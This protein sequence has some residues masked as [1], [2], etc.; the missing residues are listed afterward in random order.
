MPPPS[1]TAHARDPAAPTPRR[2]KESAKVHPV[3][4]EANGAERKM[5]AGKWR[6]PEWCSAAGA[7]GVL[8]RH[9]APALFGCGL[10]L[11]MAVEYT[12]PMVPPAAPPL[13]LGFLATAGMH[14]AV[15]ARPWLNSLLA[16]LN[17][18]FVAIQA[19]YILWAILAEGRPRAAVAALMMFTCRG[20]LGCATQLPLPEEFLGSGMDFPVGN[21]S[22]FL[23]FSGHV[24]GAVIAAADMRREGRL[25][26][27]RLYD[28]LNVMQGVRLLACRGH[29]TI[30]LAVGVGAGMLF[31]TLAG[32]YFDGK[33]FDSNA[34]ERHCRSCQCHKALLSQ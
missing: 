10:L 21:V 11:F 29:Y 3:V 9:P 17:T 23:F 15:A 18:V 22:F 34:A 5:G 12:I 27:A 4:A 24:A 26:L 7:A 31:D 14:A 19:A 8:R 6:R 25:A 30:D 1:L 28:A 16:A 32:R 20:L 13:D 33:N 2:R